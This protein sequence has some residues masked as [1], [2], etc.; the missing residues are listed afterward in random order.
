MSKF[1]GEG[2]HSIES[3]FAYRI[4]KILSGQGRAGDVD[5]RAVYVLKYLGHG[6]QHI[7]QE[8]ITKH[9]VEVGDL[10]AAGHAWVEDA[11]HAWILITRYSL[12]RRRGIRS[13]PGRAWV[14]D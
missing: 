14:E 4:R 13:T 12:P 3:K 7:S 9:L 2:D 11:T 10:P 6:N 5:Y 8:Q 1:W